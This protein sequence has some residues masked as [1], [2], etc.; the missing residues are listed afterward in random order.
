VRAQ[1]Y[2]THARKIDAGDDLLELELRLQQATLDMWTEGKEAAGRTLAHETTVRAQQRFDVDERA[3]PV[4]LE[5]LRLEY[6]A[7]LQE[8][9]PQA[10]VPVGER[11]AA[12]ARGFDEEEHLT[13]LLASAR[14]LRRMG[15]VAEA[16]ERSER[17][18]REARARVFP[19]LTL[20][21]GYWLATYLLLRG[22]GAGADEART[23]PG[24]LASRTR[25]E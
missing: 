20:D 5:A 23:A 1:T 13:A 22:R 9:D 25:D 21:G 16:L 7:A 18:Y 10:M 11:L 19:R 14:R 4:Y 24:G 12:V 8:D 2:L 3:R 15:R 6:E 17:V